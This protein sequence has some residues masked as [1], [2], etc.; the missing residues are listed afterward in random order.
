MNFVFIGAKTEAIKAHPMLLLQSWLIVEYVV[1][2]VLLK[3]PRFICQFLFDYQEKKNQ[4]EIIDQSV[5]LQ[6]RISYF[7]K[8]W[9]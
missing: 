3:T 9:D 4:K 8:L 2:V 6:Y 5:I 1:V 7:V